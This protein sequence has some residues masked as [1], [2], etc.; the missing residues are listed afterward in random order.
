M[1]DG[2]FG[3][4]SASGEALECAEIA[5]H[6]LLAARD[7]I[8]FDATAVL[9]REPE[10]YQ[11]LVAEALRRGR[12]PAYFSRGT[13]A[14]DPAGRALLALLR[15]AEENY[16]A[17][18]FA[19]YLS[20]GQM[21]V[22]ERG[23]RSP[24]AWERLLVDAAVIG[25]KERWKRRIEGLIEAR[26]AQHDASV[27][28]GIRA[29]C[30]RQ[31][32][33]L[34]SLG[35]FA[36]PL[37][38]KLE[39]LPKSGTWAGWNDALTD[40]ATVALKNP[41]GVLEFLEELSPMA[42]VGPVSLTEVLLVLQ[43]RLTNLR[44][45]TQNDRYGKVFVGAI[46]EARAMSF[47]CVFIPAVN[48]GVFPRLIAEDPLLLDSQCRALG[49][50]TSRDDAKLL[51]IAAASASERVVLS[52]SRLDLLTGR[53]K[54]PSFY[55][56]EALRAARGTEVEVREF[57]EEA[58]SATETRTG[59]PAP[60][61]FATAIDD[62]EFDLAYL[63]SA[64]EQRTRGEGAYLTKLNPHAVRSL[65]ARWVRWR[66]PWKWADGLVDLDMHAI[67][68][69][70]E[71]RPSKR[72]WS[73]SALQQFA[74]CPYRFALKGILGL[75][76]QDRPEAVQ[77]VDPVTRGR[78]Y[79]EVQ[80]RL[81][82]ELKQAGRPLSNSEVLA[83]LSSLIDQVDREYRQRLAPAIPQV[84]DA[85]IE[86]IHADLRGWVQHKT[87]LDADWTP[88]LFEYAFGVPEPEKHDEA[89][90]AKPVEAL[91]GVFLRGSVD[92]VEE[93]AN[94]ILRVVDHKTGRVPAARI[95]AVGGG[96][97]L[98]PLLY[99]LAVEQALD[100]KVSGG[101]LFYSTLRQNYRTVDVALHDGSRARV[102]QVLAT[103]DNALH[104][105]FL[106][107]APRKDGCKGC[108]FTVV[109]GPWEEERV[110]RKSTPELRPLQDVRRL[111]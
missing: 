74:R 2:S 108:E 12:I 101:R 75:E 28:A 41:E 43:E 61:D 16:S 15:C 3:I 110:A 99:A 35:A 5:R 109:C 79:H 64:W 82:R 60:S 6:I 63:R 70:D 45:E 78:I 56:F 72:A 98:Q 42:D 62:L 59:W 31:V 9:L 106:P 51:K 52:W 92:L 55:A 47:R 19:E 34:E 4:F 65:R 54:V 11:P 84:W 93:N 48:E 8:A 46:S 104:N 90:L 89:S 69:L 77:R 66:K 102:G 53:A 26:L 107:A 58:R 86:S 76:R 39:A 20:L 50:E 100:R 87:T 17:T 32:E 22:D 81:L 36:V 23:V 94:G 97:H 24:I 85:D 57:E 1:P 73:A 13:R 30:A 25:G 27:E 68:V 49:M 88:L 80:F 111:P 83:T 96:E 21:P 91:P 14:P 18:R 7:G 37:I 29:W 95:E 105:G 71:H 40:L 33:M 38:G 103:I 44:G 67:Q 10:K